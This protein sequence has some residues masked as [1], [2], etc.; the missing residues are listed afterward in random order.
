MSYF[1]N[2]MKCQLLIDK[3]VIDIER[4]KNKNEKIFLLCDTNT[5][6]LKANAD[7]DLWQKFLQTY[8]VH[9]P[10]YHRSHNKNSSK[11][12]NSFSIFQTHN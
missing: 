9:V 8:N 4:I 11:T 1:L 12:I 10:L 6:D 5:M 3:T 2:A 7:E